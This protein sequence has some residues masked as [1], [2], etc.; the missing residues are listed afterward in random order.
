LNSFRIRFEGDVD[1][2]G[3][4]KPGGANGG[5][6]EIFRDIADVLLCKTLGSGNWMWG[7]RLMFDLDEEEDTGEGHVDKSQTKPIPRVFLHHAVHA[8]HST[9]HALPRPLAY[10]FPTLNSRINQTWDDMPR[11][12]IPPNCSSRMADRN[13]PGSAIILFF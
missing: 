12:P 1:E 3:G 4:G 11:T 5:R 8:S 7:K 10:S 13:E 6:G 2:A 9:P